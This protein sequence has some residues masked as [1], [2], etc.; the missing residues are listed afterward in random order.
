MELPAQV[1]GTDGDL[2]GNAPA[3]LLCCQWLSVAL[4]TVKVMWLYFDVGVN[5]FDVGVNHAMDYA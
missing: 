5:Y 2:M 4:Q 3:R 1:L